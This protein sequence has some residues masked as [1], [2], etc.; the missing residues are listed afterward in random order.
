MG[1][2]KALLSWQGG[3]LLDHALTRLRSSCTA[4]R[5][6]GGSASRYGDRGV[7]VD[8][9]AVADAG[10][11]GGIFTGL[12]RMQ[13]GLGLFLAVDM[14]WAPVTLLRRLLALAEGYDAV[15]PVSAAGLEPLCAVYRATCLESVRRRLDANDLRVVRFLDDVRLREV[16]G[17]EL[18]AFGDPATLLRSLNTPADYAAACG[19]AEPY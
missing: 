18:T 5:I 4:V 15:V 7:P 6:L 10:A 9:D 11:L 16:S 17:A 19:V 1:R 14:P 12:L 2:D 3:T 13:T 8:L